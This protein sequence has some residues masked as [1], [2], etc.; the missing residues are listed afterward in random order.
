MP[1]LQQRI[2]DA[3]WD[4]IKISKPLTAILFA[5]Y[6][7]AITFTFSVDCQASFGETR[8]TLLTRYRAATVQALI[9][10]EFLTTKDLEVLQ[11]FVLFLLAD[12][13]SDLNSTLTGAAIRLG[14]K[15][16]LHRD[17]IDPKISFFEKEMRIRLWWQLCGLHSRNRAV[18][19][20]GMKLPP[21][22][23]G[24]VRLPLN[25]NDADLHPDM[26]EPPIEHNGPTEMLCVLMKFEV[27]NWLRSS[28]TAAKVFGD[29]IQGPVKGKMSLEL[30]DE[31]INEL[32]AIYQEKFLCKT[33]KRI[34][35]HGLTHAMANLAIARMR[36]KVHHPRG[37]TAVDG[38]EVYVTQKE[39]DMLIDSAM[40]IL[41]MVNVGINI[42]SEFSAHL[43]AH[44][45]SQP[46]MDACIYVLSELRGQCSEDRRGLAWGLVG[47]LYDEHPDLIDD[48]ENT[49]SGALGDLALEAWEAEV[50]AHGVWDPKCTPKFIQLLWDK[51]RNGDLGSAQTP[52]VPD[53]HGLD[54]FGLTDDNDLDWEY[55]NDFLQL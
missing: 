31:A 46:Q 34:P 29:I 22:E 19:T 39:R 54:G 1:N 10:A 13:E 37:R 28:P 36:F 30:E 23:L 33:D 24:D 42:H 25:V 2:L 51:R 52:T 47:N 53:A 27:S 18:S 7:L 44:L 6:T 14:Q 45:T 48:G 8:G 3:S 9:A 32:E 5:I 20:P 15:M 4:P 38:G 16:G 49:F 12:P 35:L 43:F 50:R 26:I 17:N 21:F 11:A 55:W 41:E 40:T